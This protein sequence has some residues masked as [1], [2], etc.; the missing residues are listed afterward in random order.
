MSQLWL[1][2]TGFVFVA[3]AAVGVVEF[4]KEYAAYHAGR[5]AG[6]RLAAAAGFTVMFAWFGVTSFFK[7]RRRK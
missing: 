1:E 6:S 2:V 7:V 4:I 3:F 5:T